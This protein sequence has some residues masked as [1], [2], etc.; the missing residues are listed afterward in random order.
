MDNGFA[1]FRAYARKA[2]K[3]TIFGGSTAAGLGVKDQSYAAILARRLGLEFDNLA[4][5][6][7]QITDSIEFVDKAAGSEVVLVMHGSGE[8]LIRP[9]DRSLR[10]MPPRW[11][12]RGWMD[13]RAYY[14]SKWYR[15]IPQ[16]IESA[17]RWR[18]KVT[19][20]RLSG[21]NHLIDI[22]TYLGTTAKFVERLQQL[23]VRQIVFIGSAAMDARYFPYSA[24]LIARYDAATKD[25]VENYGATFVDVLDVCERWGDYFG[26]H[27]HPNVDGH[28]RLADAIEPFLS[29]PASPEAS[30]TA[31]SADLS[32]A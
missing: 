18:V 26:D 10:F 6:S 28:R 1:A 22:D 30:R 13:P 12:R 27:L 7:A 20:I 32:A 25:L 2:M 14:S 15:R 9:T 17:I 11:R 3:L 21:G 31:S 19:L 8:A 24:E 23:G 16:K 5:S 4:G 29:Q